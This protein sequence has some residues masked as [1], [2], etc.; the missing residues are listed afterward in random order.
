MRA[1]GRCGHDNA[2]HLTYCFSCGR[3][4]GGRSPTFPPDAAN[5][6]LGGPT[7]T[8]AVG[9]PVADGRTPLTAFAATVALSN[10]RGRRAAAPGTP[11]P[12]RGAILR[13]FDALRYVFT[14]VR[15]RIDAEE[16][17][18]DLVDERDGAKRLVEGAL[19]ELGQTVLGEAAKTSPPTPELAAALDAV[20]RAES[21]R[22]AAVG[23]IA[24]AEKFLS[25]EDL[26]LA[27]EQASA[28]SE[29]K[30]CD[31]GAQGI[32]KMLHQ[33]DEERR[34][35][36][37][38][39]SRLREA[40]GGRSDALDRRPERAALDEKRARLDDQYGSLR[41]RA[42]ALRAS[43][44]AARA[45]LDH[46]IAARR[47]AAAAMAAS[48]VGHTRERADAE[49][50]VRELTIQVGRLACGLRLPDPALLPGYARVDR[51]EETIVDR[52]RQIVAVERTM[53]HYD[54]RRLATGLGV[55]TAILG[56]LG[57]SLWAVFR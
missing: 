54:A 1:C 20:A 30:A 9:A 12:S 22:R 43:T 28:E 26:R 55:L 48:L 31:T 5:I 15:G 52:D 42:A 24:V 35:L 17:R 11:P 27:S 34:A 45:K 10:V 37:A 47:Q 57:V 33:V 40:S 44:I 13:A 29:W 16:R 51:L 23:D 25:S 36:D 21:R 3:R 6:P 41:E 46:A 56:V 50:Q 7:A 53:G 19:A 49:R 2:D 8:L 39:T 38:E 14:Y 18:R 4:L 32:D